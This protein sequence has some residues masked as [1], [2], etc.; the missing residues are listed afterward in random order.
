MNNVPEHI[1]KEA[2][3][4]S[5][6]DEVVI[7]PNER[8]WAEIAKLLSFYPETRRTSDGGYKDQLWCIISEL[9]TMFYNGQSYFKNTS[10][11]IKEEQKPEPAIPL[12]DVEKMVRE[13]L[14]KEEI[15]DCDI[16]DQPVIYPYDIHYIAKKY[17]VEI[18]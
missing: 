17:G 12:K 6:N 15:I 16:V 9:H 13:M 5:M 10:V 2:A 7:Y 11:T 18:K 3:H 14:N 1:L 4:L 8:G